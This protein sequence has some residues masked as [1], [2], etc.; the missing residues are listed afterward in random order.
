LVYFFRLFLDLVFVASPL[1]LG[2]KM[3]GK[4]SFCFP[5]KGNG[6]PNTKKEAAF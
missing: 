5:E 1:N 6:G 4:L 2:L 3:K